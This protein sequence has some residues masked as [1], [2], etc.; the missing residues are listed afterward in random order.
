VSAPRPVVLVVD[1]EMVLRRTVQRLLERNG[2][3]V[4]AA[5]SGLEALELWRCHSAAIAALVTDLNMPGMSGGQ[6]VAHLRQERPDLPVLFVTG[7]S[8][9]DAPIDGVLVGIPVIRKPFDSVQ[10]VS[11]LD[12]VLGRR[13]ET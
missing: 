10:V 8:P 3:Q 11:A 12:G 1:D 7:I 5:G 6:L 9:A 2:Y 13:R 4:L